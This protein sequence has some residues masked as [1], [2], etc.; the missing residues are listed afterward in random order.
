M[1]SDKAHLISLQQ[2]QM[3]SLLM[4][5][6]FLQLD[7]NGSDVSFRPKIRTSDFPPAYSPNK[8]RR[9]FFSNVGRVA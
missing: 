8:Q 5:I 3:R 6:I 1:T 4:N 7:E 2:K 9:I